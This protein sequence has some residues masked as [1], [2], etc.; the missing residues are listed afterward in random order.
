MCI[1]NIVSDS[2]GLRFFY[3]GRFFHGMDSK[4]WGLDQEGLQIYLPGLDSS[5]KALPEV[6]NIMSS[7]VLS[8]S[9]KYIQSVHSGSLTMAG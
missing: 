2:P 6:V 3:W 4:D 1:L 8:G 5:N 7:S 9:W